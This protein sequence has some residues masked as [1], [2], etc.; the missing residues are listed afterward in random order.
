LRACVCE[1]VCVCARK[2]TGAAWNIDEKSKNPA[3]MPTYIVRY[4]HIRQ[5][6]YRPTN[7]NGTGRGDAQPASV[8]D[9]A[10]SHGWGLKGGDTHTCHAR[11]GRR[12]PQVHGNCTIGRQ[13]FNEAAGCARLVYGDVRACSRTDGH[14]SMQPIVHRRVCTTPPSTHPYYPKWCWS[15]PWRRRRHAGPSVWCMRCGRWGRCTLWRRWP[16]AQYTPPP[17]PVPSRL[18]GHVVTPSSRPHSFRSS[19]HTVSVASE[20]MPK[21]TIEM[22]SEKTN[23]HAY[24]RRGARAASAH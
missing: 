9:A 15:A 11:P 17:S 12:A 16:S 7:R 8:A 21:A 24:V 5:L 10:A 13:R 1:C 6:H 20:K 23:L 22:V 19:R 4:A 14:T 18:R 2:C 3:G